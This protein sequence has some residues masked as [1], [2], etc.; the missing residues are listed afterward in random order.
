MV[1]G[2]SFVF[3]K[4]ASRSFDEKKSACNTKEHGCSEY[5][6]ERGRDD[7]EG[8]TGLR[9]TCRHRADDEPAGGV[10]VGRR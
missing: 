4:G 3:T 10:A 6:R 2:P 8:D 9:R 1:Q 5:E 7:R